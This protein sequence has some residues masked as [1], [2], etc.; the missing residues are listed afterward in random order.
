MRTLSCSPV[1][2]AF[3][4]MGGASLPEL[5]AA[6]LDERIE[7]AVAH[8]A[9]AAVADRRWFHEH[10]E[11]GNH[12][13]QTSARVA[14]I[15]EGLG[16]K[17]ER[18]VGITGVL[19]LL[20]TGKPGPTVAIRADMDGLPVLE[21]PDT[22]N[23][24]RS[25]TPGVMHACGHDV[26]LASGLG[27]ARVLSEIR[28][29]LRGRVLFIFQPAEEGVS[30]D[31]EKEL[32]RATASDKVGADRLVNLD[33]ILEKHQVKAAFGLHGFPEGSAGSL[34]LMPEYALASSDEFEIV[35][36]GASAHAGQSP[37]LGSDVLQI[38]AGVVLELHAMPARQ[39][40]PRNPKVVSVTML[41]CS[42]GRSNILCHTAKLTGT[43]R[44]FRVDDKREIRIKF[45]NI[46]DGAVKAR[47]PQAGRCQAGD[48]P[49]RLCWEIPV[50]DDYGP[51]VHQ[52]PELLKWSGQVLRAALGPARV[53]D[54]PAS[55][56]AE[57]FAYYCEAVP[58]SFFSLGTA[59]PGGT[60]GL[61]TPRYAP[62]EDAIPVGVRA[63]A[64]VAAHYLLR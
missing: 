13:L 41:D 42:D 14:Q 50:W 20:D 58:C 43:V 62:S 25:L 6:D 16:L 32:L 22:K 38:A 1:A 30:S 36:R 10:V 3:L 7:S 4:L 34:G 51:A 21:P 29:E 28:G 17:V 63:L 5:A 52:N 2:V 9:A 44:T 11:L 12:E 47:D 46:L 40:D 33:K 56:G 54:V 60:G 26:H 45:E 8:H 37:W 48:L 31:E 23:P 15:L 61:H 27:A 18:N 59:P 55:L 39:L 57:D 64:T 24:V 53:P 35:I 19:G 49:D